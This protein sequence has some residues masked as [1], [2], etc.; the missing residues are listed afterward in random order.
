M[1]KPQDHHLS[2]CAEC[3]ASVYKEHLDAGI[4][5]YEGD[6]LLCSV[7]VAEYER[8]H[9]GVGGP[10][11][12]APIEFDDD[13]DGMDSG[14]SSSEMAGSTMSST[15][16]HSIS[17]AT[18]GNT[19]GWDDSKF[20]RQLNPSAAGA[21]R[22]RTFHCRLSDGAIEFMMHQMNDWM[23]SND[24]IVIK[25]VNSSIGLFE[26]KHTEQNLMVTVFY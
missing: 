13:D 17:A 14:S 7:C 18:L 3:G 20:K 1:S 8:A 12:L 15:R 24:E 9:D 25:F 10:D 2:T 22:C 5:R 23:D 21:S 4:A 16:I 26:G 19:G 11:D 6:R